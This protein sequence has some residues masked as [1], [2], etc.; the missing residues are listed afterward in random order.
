MDA[1][2]PN[3]DDLKDLE[4]RLGTWSPTREG[5]DPDAMLFAAGRASVHHGKSWIVWPIASGT[6]AL[7][8]VT[9]G[10]WVTAERSERVA[11]QRELQLKYAETNPI[12]PRIN[13]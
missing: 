4:N 5:L 10:I 2:I 6:L 12:S 13:T 11:L 9:L 7:A 3:T 8:V 1:N